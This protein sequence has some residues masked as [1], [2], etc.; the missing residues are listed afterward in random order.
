MIMGD[1]VIIDSDVV[2]KHKDEIFIGN[3]VA[4]DKGFYCTTKLTLEDYIHI[5]PYVVV[6]GG[7]NSKL[8]MEHFS[9]IASGSKIIAGSDSYTED[10][11]AGSSIPLKYRIVEY[12][13]VTFKKFAICGVNCSIMPGVVIGEGSMIGA[14]SV[15]T[16]DTEPW[17]VYVGSPAKPVKY[18]EHKN[19]L[20]YAKEL[21]Y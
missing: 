17:T 18:R 5:A 20:K 3:H 7:R 4:I 11:L 19:I 1:D 12:T 9:G 6:I 13:T 2:L 21:G 8:I 14:N 15:V 10:A 16:K